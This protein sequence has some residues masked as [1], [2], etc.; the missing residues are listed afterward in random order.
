[1]T[2]ISTTHQTALCIIPPENLWKPIQMIR[3]IH[4]KAYARWMPH[5][6]LIYPFVPESEF[7]QTKEKL[8]RVL[9]EQTPFDIE[10]DQSS[11]QY[12]KQKGQQCTFHLRPKISAKTVEIQNQIQNALFKSTGGTTPSFE[13]HLTL[14]QTTTSRISDV[15]IEMKSKWTPIKF[16]VD[17]L[18]MIS[19]EN[20]PNEEFSIKKQI[21]L[22]GRKKNDDEQETP[23][24]PVEENPPEASLIATPTIKNKS[25]SLATPAKLFLCIIPPNEF[26]TRLLHLFEEIPSFIP[27]L[28][29]RIVLREY[30]QHPNESELDRELNNISKFTL[31][32][33]PK[34]I[35]FNYT[36]VRL[37]LKPT[38]C[39]PAI[40]ILNV[41]DQTD[42]TMTL[43]SLDK[44]DLT[45]IGDL[46][47]Q[48]WTFGTN[49]FEVDRLHLLDNQNRFR[50]SF[51]LRNQ[52]F[53]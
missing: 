7:D 51:R 25:R 27:S 1:M 34:S 9:Q 5:I 3:S 29:L 46:Y 28:P 22:L 40:P 50:A 8:E 6:N 19:R 18:A 41:N 16:T 48:R 36:S 31:D 45:A 4:D 43:G 2:N 52:C 21:F 35:C 10:F 26:S 32:F 23:E 17:R 37:F 49:E 39:L 53:S 20:D 33:G 38:T 14:G 44:K 12:F 42:N 24:E 47:T 11:I 30:D 13:A 15:L